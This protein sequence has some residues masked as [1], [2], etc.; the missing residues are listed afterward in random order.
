MHGFDGR[1]CERR[2]IS[3]W[4]LPRKPTYSAPLDRTPIL[5]THSNELGQSIDRI[6]NHSHFYVVLREFIHPRR[7]EPG[8]ADT[9]ACGSRPPGSCSWLYR[10][11][12][13]RPVLLLPSSIMP[14]A[15]IGGLAGLGIQLYV[16]TIRKLPL[17]RNPWEHVILVGAGAAFGNWLVDFEERTAEDVRGRH[18]LGEGM[19]LA[20]VGRGRVHSSY[21]SLFLCVGATF[22]VALAKR[23]AAFKH[24]QE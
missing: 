5:Q 13:F 11:S 18:W 1:E 12:A 8:I 17:L 20:S 2:E 23:E 15:V 3:V 10:S 22:T 21:R 9:S 24:A 19:S 14:A 6:S 7:I 4:V 16:N